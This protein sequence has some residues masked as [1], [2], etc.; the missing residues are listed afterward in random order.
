MASVCSSV[1]V[2][3]ASFNKPAHVLWHLGEGSASLLLYPLSLR[4]QSVRLA[5]VVIEE[6]VAVLNMAVFKVFSPLVN[7]GFILGIGLIFVAALVFHDIIAW[8]EFDDHAQNEYRPE[9]VQSL[10]HK[11]QPVE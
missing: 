9:D 3:V 7:L 8:Q 10:Q 4:L 5:V 1:S 11:H 6:S 2:C